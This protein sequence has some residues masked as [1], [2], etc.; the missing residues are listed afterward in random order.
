MIWNV[1]AVQDSD[2][3]PDLEILEV[4]LSR[5]R[6]IPVQLEQLAQIE[7]LVA[8]AQGW[9]DRASRAFLKKNVSSSCTLLQVCCLYTSYYYLSLSLSLP[10]SCEVVCLAI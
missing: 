7:S 4:L 3:S 1:A 5:A 9:R 6:A 10:L 8:A 2:I